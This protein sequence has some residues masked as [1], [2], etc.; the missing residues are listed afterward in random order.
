MAT[1][2][3]AVMKYKAK[4]YHRVPLDLRNEDF[5]ELKALC[6]SIGMPVN[7]FI[8]EAIAEKASRIKAE[9]RQLDDL[10]FSMT[11]N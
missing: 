1:S 10:K 8:R 7:T 9:Q 2:V 11:E 6:E 3:K 5:D 4:T